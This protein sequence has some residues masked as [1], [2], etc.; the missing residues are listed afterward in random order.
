[1]TPAHWNVLS[2]AVA[3]AVGGYALANMVPIAVVAFFSVARVDAALIALQLSFVI[4][5]VAVMWAF[6]ARSAR[7]AW[8][9]I[10]SLALLA[11][12][13]AWARL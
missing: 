1:M 3:A 6:A 2:R 13:V 9:G 11:G 5:A 4:Y 12:V 10:G 8:A 7:S